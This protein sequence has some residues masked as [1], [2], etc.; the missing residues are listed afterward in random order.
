M[1]ILFILGYPNPFPGAGWTRI[2]FFAKHFKDRRYN[3][4]VG[5]F[6]RREHTLVLSWK[7][8]PVYSVPHKATF[9]RRLE[10]R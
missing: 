3:V 8:I 7:W 9:P 10:L 5:I 2:G 4:A 1:K 6:P